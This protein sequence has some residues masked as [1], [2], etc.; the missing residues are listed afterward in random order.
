MST[1][2]SIQRPEHKNLPLVISRELVIFPGAVIPFF[3][4]EEH[5]VSAL[6][7]AFEGDRM[8]FFAFPQEAEEDEESSD[9]Q[10]VSHAGSS[11]INIYRVGTIVKVLQVFKLQ[12]G[13]VRI[14]A[15]A[16]HR[17]IIRQVYE[18]DQISRVLVEPHYT[19]PPAAESSDLRVLMAA[20]KKYF[21]E[22]AS[23]QNKVPKEAQQSIEE[24]D[25]PD[26]LVDLIAASVQIDPQRK[27]KLLQIFD[28]RQRLQELAVILQTEQ[29]LLKLHG[30]IQDKVREKI[31]QSQKEYFLNEQIR[32][33]NKELG[34]DADE[35]DEPDMFFEQIKAKSPPQEVL[36]KA[37]KEVDRLK[38]LQPMA[39]E[40][41]VLRTYL[42]WLADLPW[43]TYTE[44]TFDMPL[45]EKILDEDHYDMKRPK[46]RIL[47][48]M[49]V[50]R[51]HPKLK[52]PILCFVGPPGTGKTSLGRS[53]AR[54][55]GKNFIRI[56]LGG[57]RDEAEIR[58]HRKTYVGALPGKIIQS[59][60][61]AGTSN[62]VFLLDEVDKLSSD[63]RG[64]PSSA[65][66]EVLDPEQNSTFTDHY[67][68]VPYDLSQV[69]FIATANSLHTIPAALRDRMEI[70]ELPG[71]SDIEK[72]HI[73]RKFLIPKQLKENGLADADITFKKS[74]I[75]SLI[76][77]YTMES[78]VRNLE[79]SISSVV[80]KLAREYLNKPK[81]AALDAY[82]RS[83]TSKTLPSLLGTPEYREDQ[84]LKNPIPGIAHGLAWTEVGG[85][86]LTAEAALLPG[87][88]N[89]ILTGSLGEVMKESARISYSFL[90][91]N[92]EAYQIDPEL[93][94]T[95]NIH[96]HVPQGAI[97]KD[98]PSAGLTI[99]ASMASAFSKRPIRQQI[100]M[101]GEITLSGQILRIGG[102]KEKLLAS[103]RHG[104]T[105]VLMP[106]GNRQDLD[107]DIP[108][109]VLQALKIIHYSRA[110]EALHYLLE[111]PELQEEKE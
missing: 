94:K 78:G 32:Q 6:N 11:S 1:R 7:Q 40:A 44:D 12:D 90:Q 16:K 39:P 80:R 96:L 109:S 22:Y 106:E 100:S 26:R 88:G 30:Q 51:L 81:Q 42:E 65:L 9:E 56:S 50:R 105:T 28:T 2:E 82:H 93:F 54:A 99:L 73:A 41:G 85:K 79:R 27:I 66:L 97:P 59:I 5:A 37:R 24:E 108:K 62:P 60:K 47:D 110:D 23:I 15:E 21:K 75:Y 19:Q 63:F 68:E 18:Q 52:G 36:D 33:I 111:Q 87:D 53:V 38:K 8:V 77:D 45:A 34:R 64:D 72:Y 86:L 3:T 14:L 107:D 57:V 58:G 49:A 31:E 43:G 55:L 103:Y 4:S 69:L 71:Y 29:E 102:V 25:N 92:H 74:A 13:S 20:V 17:G 98:G 89:L 76:R 48:Y 84:V 70:I 101:T 91:A 67:L 104:I 35:A 46:D 61:K 95:C 10:E 83:V